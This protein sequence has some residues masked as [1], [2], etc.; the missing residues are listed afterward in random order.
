M[1]G[2]HRIAA[3]KYCRAFR[4]YTRIARDQF[5]N[6]DERRPV[7]QAKVQIGPHVS[8]LDSSTDA[9]LPLLANLA[10]A[11]MLPASSKRMRE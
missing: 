2:E 1:A 9:R 5:L 6:K 10:N 3:P 8:D 7:G 4:G 11:A